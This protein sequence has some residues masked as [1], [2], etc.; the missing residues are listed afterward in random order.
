M[1]LKERLRGTVAAALILLPA[2][3]GG[4]PG[5]PN[6]PAAGLQSG[7]KNTATVAIRFALR[8]AQ[9]KRRPSYVSPSSQ[10]LQVTVDS[11]DGGAPPSWISPNPEAIDFSTSGANSNCTIA[12][13]VE[14]CTLS[15]PAP[16]GNVAY[17]FE[18]FDKPGAA[19]NAL[20]MA[21]QTVPITPGQTT[22][23][24]VTMLGIVANVAVSALP[25]VPSGGASPAPSSEALSFAAADADGNPIPAASGEAFSNPFVLSVTDQ[26]DAVTLASGSSPVCPGTST[27]TVTSA[28]QQLWLCY[29]GALTSGVQISATASPD[30]PPGQGVSGGGDVPVAPIVFTGAVPCTPAAG[31]APSDPNY[32]AP[33]LFFSTVTGS[34]ATQTFGAGEPGWTDPPANGQFDLALDP[35]TCGSGSAAVVTVSAG[36]ATSWTVT[37]QNPGL[38]KGT[39]TEHVS[40]PAGGSTDVWFSVTTDGEGGY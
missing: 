4:A 11:V 8:S 10:S 17:T 12:S 23:I 14:T 27:L 6:A 5:A 22:P 13:G 37:A 20:G 35:A 29:T 15:V 3:G 1:G 18:L 33:T 24:A 30:A 34:A 16:P 2:C 28:A 19:G 32:G 31:C 26:S 39:L 40:P 21:R 25:L 7:S 36:P 38:C 9:S